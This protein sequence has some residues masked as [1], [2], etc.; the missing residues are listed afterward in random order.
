MCT[1]INSNFF[2]LI[3]YKSSNSLILGTCNT[4]FESSYYKNFTS[5][6][7]FC[8]CFQADRKTAFNSSFAHIY[9]KLENVRLSRVCEG[10][11]VKFTEGKIFFATYLKPHASPII[12]IKGI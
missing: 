11:Q 12:Q 5:D 9:S 4:K 1:A 7:F 2:L 8:V 3:V 10:E 6:W